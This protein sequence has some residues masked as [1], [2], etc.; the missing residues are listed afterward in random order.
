MEPPS[1]NLVLRVHS[2]QCSIQQ[3]IAALQSNWA[4]DTHV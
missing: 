2:L 1:L 4:M 3:C